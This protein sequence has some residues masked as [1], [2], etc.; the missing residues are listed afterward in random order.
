VLNTAAVGSAVLRQEDHDLLG[1][2]AELKWAPPV[3]KRTKKKKTKR[4]KI[5]TARAH[6]KTHAYFW[7]YQMELLM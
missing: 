5:K 7:L 6:T 4:K 3:K 1:Y 2:T